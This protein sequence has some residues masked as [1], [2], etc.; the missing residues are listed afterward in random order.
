[1]YSPSIEDTMGVDPK[2]IIYDDGLYTATRFY[3]QI[4]QFEE[5]FGMIPQRANFD[6]TDSIDL[7]K[8]CFLG[9]ELTARA[10]FNGVIRK[11][12]YPFYLSNS[13][14]EFDL[15]ALDRAFTEN[16]AGQEFTDEAGKK[17]LKVISKPR[18]LI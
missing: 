11:R 17:V 8:G 12:P 16:L 4:L 7:K 14:E 18:K 13:D 1:M 15:K 10:S 9:Q 2:D 5:T 3:H 6:L